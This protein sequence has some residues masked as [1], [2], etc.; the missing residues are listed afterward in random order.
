[1]RLCLLNAVY[2]DGKWT[3][4][5]DPKDT[6]K[7]QFVLGDGSL[8]E[9]PFMNRVGNYGFLATKRLK[10]IRL[11]YGTGRFALYIFVPGLPREYELEA[12]GDLIR[13]KGIPYS[14]AR[15]SIAKRRP[16][17]WWELNWLVSIATVDSIESWIR[18]LHKTHL[19]IGVPKFEAD[20]ADS[21]RA[22]LT[23]LGAG[24]MFDSI[25]AD[26]TGIAP[27]DE[28]WVDMVLHK[29]VIEVDEA[30]TRAAAATALG[31]AE[32]AMVFSFAADRPFF[33]LIRD[34]HTGAIL[35]L[36]TLVDP[37]RGRS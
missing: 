16:P 3:D 30:G 15:D 26:L 22:A 18:Q 27:G 23:R 35:F 31:V 36:G 19:P 12:A 25:R 34:D 20:Y 2:F 24:I 10:A 7:G 8:V 6:R 14:A 21:L 17:P 9:H 33:Y 32:C 4:V 1:V 29:C 5:F 11:P 37:R 13:E 28:R